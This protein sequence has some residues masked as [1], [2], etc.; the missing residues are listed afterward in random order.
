MY[1]VGSITGWDINN[2]WEMIA[3]KAAGRLGKVFYSYVRLSTNDEFKFVKEVGNWGSAYG[4]T[5]G[6]NGDFTTGFNN[7]GNFVAPSAGIYR[8]T[9]DLGANKAYVQQKQVG[10]VGNMQGWNQTAPT[11]GGIAGRNRFIIV[12]NANNDEFK[13][14][15]GPEWDNSAPNKT[16]WWGKGSANGLLDNDGNGPNLMSLAAP[17][18][19]AIWDASDPQQVKYDLTAAAEM[20]VVGNGMN[21]PGVNDWDPASSPQMTYMG[22]GRWQITLALKADKEIKFLAGNAWGAFDYE[23]NADNGSAGGTIRRTIRWDG[24]NN[25]KTPLTA[26][27]YTI[28]LDEHAQ[29]VTI[30]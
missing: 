29:T 17:R 11:F 26:G 1:L 10:L 5:G 8:L 13:F 27:T 25:F 2:P 21:V 6:S 4:Q 3:D 28:V 22:N 24:S 16:R 15:E 12:A 14:H 30:N 19:R 18:T 7:G 9:I 23:D 20:R